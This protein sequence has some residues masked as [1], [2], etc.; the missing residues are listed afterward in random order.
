MKKLIIAFTAIFTLATTSSF[1]KDETE[2]VKVSANVKH[3]F[4][5][6]F[7]DA[8]N[9]SWSQLNDLY[10]AE[11]T[12][13]DEKTFAYFD[14][15]GELAILA[16][17]ITV[18]QLNKAQQANLR[19]EYAGFAITNVYRLEDTDDVRYFA[20]V[21]NAGQRIILSTTGTKWSLVKATTK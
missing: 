13:D 21:E 5:A 17:P 18:R 14:G 9:V 2:E 20:V 7:S 11:F 19:K 12:V 6:K 15:S 10:V 16:Q 4:Q 1:A 3:A 8:I